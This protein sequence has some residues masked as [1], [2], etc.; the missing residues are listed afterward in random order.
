MLKEGGKPTG[1][2]ITNLQYT[3]IQLEKN[4]KSLRLYTGSPETESVNE[5]EKYS[6]DL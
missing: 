5:K 4:H 6:K 2:M 3:A 1:D